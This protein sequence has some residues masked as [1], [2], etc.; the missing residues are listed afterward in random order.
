MIM[1]DMMADDIKAL[2]GMRMRTT[3]MALTT[4]TTS[5]ETRPLQHE[6]NF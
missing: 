1:E 5:I 3:R 6:C 2:D 4:L